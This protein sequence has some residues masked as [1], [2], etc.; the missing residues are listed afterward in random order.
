MATRAGEGLGENALFAMLDM[1]PYGYIWE[2]VTMQIKKA[3]LL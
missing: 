2:L 3:G 1:R